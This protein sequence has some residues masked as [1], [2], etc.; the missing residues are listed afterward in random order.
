MAVDWQLKG[1]SSS[2][3]L[4]HFGT[5]DDLVAECY[6]SVIEFMPRPDDWRPG[7]EVTGYWWPR[8][9]EGWEPPSEVVEFLES[10]FAPVFL[11]LGS[12]MLSESS[13]A[14]LSE[15]IGRAL[16]LAGV[17][18]IVQSGGAGLNVADATTLTIGTL[19]HDWLFPR[20][21]AAAHSCGAGTTAAALRAGIP[22][23]PIP[24]PGGDQPFWARRLHALGASPTPLPRPKLTP[25]R[26]ARAIDDALANPVYRTGTQTLAAG[27]TEENGAAIAVDVIE[28]LLG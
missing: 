5:K 15:T 9:P 22:T 6:R 19:P 16:Q 27:I 26:L 23:I 8:R 20:M 14:R 28:K 11:G 17:R 21:A 18:G 3:V 1:M 13:A 2:V 10:G 25:E 7:L 12:L 4:Y 24:L